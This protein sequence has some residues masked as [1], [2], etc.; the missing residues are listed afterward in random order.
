MIGYHTQMYEWLGKIP[1]R[2]DDIL[3]FMPARLTAVSFTLASFITR[4]DAKAAWQIVLR[5]AQ[6][7][8]SPNAGYPMSAMASALEIELEKSGCYRL[9][10]GK[11]KPTSYDIT[12]A[13][14]LMFQAT[15]L[16]T[17]FLF[18]LPNR[19]YLAQSRNSNK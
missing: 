4:S 18:W 6:L 14:H 2:V 17:F 16:A 1:A 5:D 11:R 19:K 8:E 3:N 9:G 7:T 13:R 10:A 12:R 15:I